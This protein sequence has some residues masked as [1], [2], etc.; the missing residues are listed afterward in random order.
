M[1][2]QNNGKRLISI[3]LAFIFKIVTIK[4]IA[5]IIEEAP[6]RCKLNI[7]QST[8]ELECPVK[9]LNGG[10]KVQPVPA[11]PSIH[12]DN[13]SKVKDGGSNQKLRLFKRGKAMSG[14]PI[15]NGIIQLPKPP[16]K[17]GIATKKIIIKP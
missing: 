9:L 8:A 2:Q 17:I 16:N 7:T 10:Y 12:P 3:P 14:A 1:D 5:P 4:F 11:P 13:I 15:N 6:A